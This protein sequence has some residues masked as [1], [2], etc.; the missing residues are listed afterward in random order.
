MASFPSHI[1]FGVAIGVLS[2]IGVVTAAV[3]KDPSLSIAIFVATTLGSILPDMDSDSGIPFHVTFGSLSIVSA[4]LVFWGIYQR[5]PSN[6]LLLAGGTLVTA[7]FIWTVVAHVFKR[8]TRHRGMAHSLPA[9]LLAGLVIFFVASRLSF[10]DQHAFLL[11]V[12]MIAGYV[13]HLV[14]DEI[15]AAFNFHGQIFIPNKALG[16]AFKLKSNSILV[17]I[18]MFSAIAF[19]I[20]GNTGRLLRLAQGFWQTL[21][22]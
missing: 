14:L 3:T 7:V 6:W 19:L 16:T 17:N 2:V 9:A 5:A 20:T 4:G 15:Y 8:F 22:S 12:A 11:G 21:I 10:S 18:L 1:S 13:S